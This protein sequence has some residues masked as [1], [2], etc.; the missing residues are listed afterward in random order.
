MPELCDRRAVVTGASSG[1][2]LVVSRELARHGAQ[3]VMAVR[4]PERG[5]AALERVRAA[6]PA[7]DVV[8]AQLDLADLA[9]VR[10]FAAGQVGVPIDLL[11]CDAGVMATPHRTT[12]DGFELQLGTNHLGHFALTGLL[13]PAL[14]A[15]DAPRVTVVSSIAHR[16]GRIDFDDL[17]STKAYRKWGAYGQSKLANLL[18]ALEL[19]RLA[20][21]A[22]TPLEV[23][24]AHPGL[25]ATGLH[26]RGRASS[27]VSPAALLGSLTRF[28]SQS[29]ERGALPVLYAATVP[30]LPP[31]AYVGPDGL[32]EAH[33]WPT[34]VGRTGAATDAVA[35]RR[36]WL[37]S[38]TLTAVSYDFES[39]DLH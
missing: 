9:S 28:V 27:R 3:V 21:E 18:F 1:L 34:L 29:A 26:T 24:A 30:G 23:T 15:T 39:P 12:V 22:G 6:V 33:G 4:D 7:A 17:M 20:V 8:T 31:A 35:A 5:A 14:L 32:G 13:L 37:A 19:Q 38:E 25:V 36:L 11:V 16:S 10:T 2:G